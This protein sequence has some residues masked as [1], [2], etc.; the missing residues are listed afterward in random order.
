MYADIFQ[1]FDN[2]YAKLTF[3]V[4]VKLITIHVCN[5]ERLIPAGNILTN[6]RNILL[7]R[8]VII[9]VLT[10]FLLEILR[11]NDVKLMKIEYWQKLLHLRNYLQSKLLLDFFGT[12]YVWLNYAEL[13]NY[14]AID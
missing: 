14:T 9:I 6:W 3:L 10:G 1:N 13:I 2:I 11:L 12:L 5:V 4:F 7:F 8:T